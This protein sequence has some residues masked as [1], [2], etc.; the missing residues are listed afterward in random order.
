MAGENGKQTRDSAP[1]LRAEAFYPMFGGP[2]GLSLLKD[3]RRK[4]A[5]LLRHESFAFLLGLPL[6][7]LAQ[8]LQHGRYD[9][10]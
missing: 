6:L 5:L 2:D 10:G 8:P 7:A 9:D 4:R 3:L 1:E